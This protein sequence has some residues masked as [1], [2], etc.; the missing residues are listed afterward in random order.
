MSY[1]WAD[2]EGYGVQEGAVG[3]TIRWYARRAEGFLGEAGLAHHD[4]QGVMEC[5]AEDVGHIVRLVSAEVRLIRDKSAEFRG[6]GMVVAA[7]VDEERR[8]G[9]GSR[10]GPSLKIDIRLVDVSAPGA[11]RQLS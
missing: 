9:A 1:S 10:L 4:L 11:Y 8:N 6:K 5:S 7:E 3:V 2:V